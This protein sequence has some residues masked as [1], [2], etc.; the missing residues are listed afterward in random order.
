MSI[1]SRVLVAAATLALAS[2]FSMVGTP[3]ANAATPQ[4]GNG[5]VEIFSRLFGTSTDPNFVETVSHGVAKIGQPMILARASSSNPAQD[6]LPSM[7]GLVSDFYHA[8]L[9]S[10]EVNRHYGNLRATQIEYAPFGVASGLCVGLATAAFQGEGL[11]LQRCSVSAKTVWIV[12]TA[13]SPTTAAEGFFPLV[14]GSTTDFCHP[15]AM[16]YP[17]H[18]YPTHKPATQIRVRHLINNPA[19]VPD[20]QLWG[21]AFGVLP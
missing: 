3:S 13:D 17:R 16:T 21:T 4:C 12:D 8:G 19:D 9:V 11:T 6:L 15:F 1:K 20:R 18:A 5:C 2:G 7:A 10:A 14:N